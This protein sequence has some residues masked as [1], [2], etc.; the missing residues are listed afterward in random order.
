MGDTTCFTIAGH[1]L[2]QLLDIDAEDRRERGDSGGRGERLTADPVA[3][4]RL[5]DADLGGQF[6]LGL[7]SLAKHFAKRHALYL[8]ERLVASI[9]IYLDSG[10]VDFAEIF[11]A[12]LKRKGHTHASFA[13]KT[14]VSA[15][16]VSLVA[17]RKSKPPM[18][19]M[20]QW[21]DE[22]GLAGPER[23][24]FKMYAGLTQIRDATV[25]AAIA[26]E[27]ERLRAE[28]AELAARVRR[29]R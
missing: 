10:V 11:R 26:E 13:E 18:D 2:T 23:S 12:A 15:A 3:D 5:E 7:G 22:L 16:F 14:G 29:T 27:I 17:T 21:A 4:R 20:D 8:A 19:R 28:V 25:S 6:G 24:Q 9:A 1:H